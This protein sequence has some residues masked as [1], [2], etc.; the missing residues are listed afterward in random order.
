MILIV[1]VIKG[2]A[3]VYFFTKALAEFEH[4]NCML[5]QIWEVK[6][7]ACYARAETFTEAVASVALMVA[8]PSVLRHFT[9]CVGY[10]WSIVWSCLRRT[11]RDAVTL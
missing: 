8:T 5:V 1:Y 6:R 10:L 2:V 7:V 4:V 3:R 11:S 9:H